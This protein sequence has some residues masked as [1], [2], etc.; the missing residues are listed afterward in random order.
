MRAA[1]RK[2]ATATAT[3]SMAAMAVAIGPG[4]ASGDPGSLYTGP[5]PRPGPNILYAPLADAPQLQN[6]GVWR[7]PPI[8]VSGASAYRDG[9]FLYQ[10]FLYDD[11]GARASTRDP[12]DQRPQ[13]GGQGTSGD[14]F[15]QPNGTYTYPTDPRYADNAADL[16]E[17][18]VRPLADATA[19]RITL[20]SLKD[21]SLVA[22][23]IAIGGTPG[24]AVPYPHGA[25]VSGPAQMFLTVHGSSAD[26]LTAAG[27][28][29][30]GPAPTVSVDLTRRQIQVLLPHSA[31]NP[32]GQSV[33][34]GAGT[35]L[36]DPATARYLIPQGQADAT[37]PGGASGLA[38]PAAFF[39]VAFRYAEP[40]PQVSDKTGSAVD[41]PS[42]WRDRAQGGALAAGDMSPFSATVDF[43]KL[44]AT[45]NDDMPGQPAGVPQTGPMDRIMASHFETE[46][47]Q[48]YSTACANTQSCKGELRGRLQPY[49][50]Y[51]PRG[52]R[53]AA[54]YGM[55]LLLHSLSANYN[56]Y[57]ATNNQSQF[58]QRGPGSI[59]ITPS[60]RGPDGW[61][62]D[63][64]GADTFEAWADTA[65]H[66]KLDPAFT[67]ITGY[68]MGG[69][70]TYKLATQFPDLFAKGQ[71]TVGPPG[72]G[73]WLPPNPPSGGTQS[74][75][76]RQLASLRNIPFLMWVEASDELV[77]F[78]GTQTQARGFDGLG[79][80]YEFDAFSPG[81]HLGLAIN[82]QFQPAADFLGDTKVNRDPAH[83]TYVY[84]PTMD[85]PAVG[86]TAGHAY[87]ASGLKLRDASGTA[88]LGSIDVRSEGFGVGDPVAGPTQ[89]GG[90]ALTGGTLPAVA[91][92]SQSRSWGLTPATPR[93]NRLDINA[94][95]VSELTIDPARA[96]VDCQAALSIHSD[97]PLRVHLAGCSGAAASLPSSRVC[98]SRRAFVIHVRRPRGAR[99]LAVAVSVNGHRV[100][101]RGRR[102]SI[103]LRGLPRGTF[104]V[105][106]ALR[107]R[108]GG[109]SRTLT[110]TRRYHTCARS[111]GRPRRSH[112]AHRRPS[113]R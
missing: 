14:I 42:F 104:T 27:T 77:P 94:A 93:V 96:H 110:Q 55:T 87:W 38:R 25:N 101:T 69:Y 24:V 4:V 95:N 47:G 113:Q 7:A 9:E 66:Y 99:L 100:R 16:V 61:Y 112:R 102:A 21:P 46:Q 105:R 15:S 18:R 74:L 108:R 58:G 80:R 85:F 36:W 29:V 33:R 49:A 45:T 84:N 107:V 109:H 6:T 57:L 60:G 82:D 17:L 92:Q 31:W 91:F 11:H 54:G 73:V 35:G 86:T 39:N 90:G 22:T 44:A 53:P 52:P 26:L 59:V 78:T 63:Y 41:N 81:D 71:P 103:V 72:L 89:F 65:A 34:L 67:V 50:I 68:S 37:H 62:Y 56:Q 75:S 51:V 83:V 28:P 106:L 40:F 111:G 23:T 32:T 5:G 19:F 3:V 30:A 1:W 79:Y 88:P 12:G 97:G 8:L 13:P 48:D 2:C 98:V 70:G 20:N 64:A 43:P 76:F 10:D